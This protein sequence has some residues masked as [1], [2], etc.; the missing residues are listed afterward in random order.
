L[1]VWFGLV[2]FGLACSVSLVSSVLFGGTRYSWLFVWLGLVWLVWFAW[3]GTSFGFGFG[4]VFGFGFEVG[5]GFCFGKDFIYIYFLSVFVLVSV[6]VLKLEWFGLVWFGCLFVS[7]PV[8]VAFRIL[9]HS[10][11]GTESTQT[12]ASP[13]STHC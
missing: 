9:I 3:F 1:F 7:I 10:F 12:V 5:I 4:S 2:W 11:S 6:L 13:N 8:V